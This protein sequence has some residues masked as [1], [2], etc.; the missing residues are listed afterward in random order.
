ML[1][2]TKRAAVDA[3]PVEG[4]WALPDGWRWE[5]LGNL[6]SYI[7][8]GRGPKYVQTDGVRVINQRCVRWAGVDLEP[9][10][11]TSTEAAARLPDEQLLRDGDILWNSTGTGTIGRAAVYRSVDSAAVVADSHVTIVRLREL[12]PQWVWLWINT[13]RV[14]QAVA[15]TGS[16]NQ[17]ELA[18]QT[19][20][21]LPIPVPP[22]DALQLLLS[23]ID[24]LFAEIDDGKQALDNIESGLSAYRD[25]LIY[26]GMIGELTA[27]WRRVNDPSTTG[28]K[29]LDDLLQ[30]RAQGLPSGKPR[31]PIAVDSTQLPEL[32]PTW[33]WASLDQ[34]CGLITSGSRAWSPYYDRGAC[35]FIMAQNVRRGRYDDRFVQLVDPPLDDPERRRTQVRRDDLLLT[36][37]GANTGDL[38]QVNFDPLDHFVCQSVAL[39][40]PVEPRTGALIE[41]FFSSA[42]GRALQM[43]DCIYGAGRPHLSFDQI[44]GLAVPFPPPDEAAEIMKRI[45]DQADRA[46]AALLGEIDPSALRQS[47]LATAFRGD[48]VA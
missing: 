4:L 27:D 35:V 14:Q 12:E 21:D 28:R 41:L 15:G 3:G 10:K 46:P 30:R 37:V 45:A 26:A 13:I 44:K 11:L 20:V 9:C 1:R 17:V 24:E 18:R 8:R 36:I 5:R 42:Y 40:R 29:F 23:R 39:L 43:N 2:G 7:S 32:P 38:C 31:T 33:C 19:V 16:T 22:P 47:I 6:C 48:L 25:A 34:L